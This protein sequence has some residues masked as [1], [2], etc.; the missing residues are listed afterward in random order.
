MELPMK[1]LLAF[2]VLVA[3]VVGGVGYWR[4]WFEFNKTDVTVNKEKFKEDKAAFLKTAGAKLKAMKEKLE[5]MRSKS[6][7]LTGEDKAKADREIRELEE[8]HGTLDT[9]LKDADK[10]ADEAFEGVKAD[11]NKALDELPKSD[12]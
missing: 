12:K 6:K 9:K 10:A 11:L 3:L 4:G 7:D 1:K 2:L 5:G 8:K